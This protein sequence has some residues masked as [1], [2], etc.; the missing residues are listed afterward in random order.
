MAREDARDEIQYCTSS[1][2]IIFEHTC[3]G[4]GKF[5]SHLDPSGA[6]GAARRK[7]WREEVERE[8]HNNIICIMHL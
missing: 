1:Y 5:L 4:G 8:N 3:G 7:G 2:R 6:S